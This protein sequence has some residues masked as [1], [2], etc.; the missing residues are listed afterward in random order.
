M[1]LECHIVTFEEAAVAKAL[2]GS[3]FSWTRNPSLFSLDVARNDGISIIGLGHVLNKSGGRAQKEGLGASSHS[4]GIYAFIYS[5]PYYHMRMKIMSIFLLTPFVSAWPRPKV[6][7]IILLETFGF[8]KSWVLFRNWADIYCVRIL[9]TSFFPALLRCNWHITLYKF[10][11]FSGDDLIAL[12]IS[13]NKMECF[14]QQDWLYTSFT[15]HNSSLFFMLRTLKLYSHKHISSLGY[16]I[17]IY[18]H[19][20][21][22]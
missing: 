5:N 3:M 21:V 4:L 8:W 15:S 13:I 18:S 7:S 19:N 11:V 1:A 16:G 10:K 12:S 22:H 6:V 2:T 17:V 9:I 20:A 14:L